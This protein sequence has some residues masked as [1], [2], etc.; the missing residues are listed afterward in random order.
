MNSPLASHETCNNRVKKEL[1][2]QG[3]QVIQEMSEGKKGKEI[4]KSSLLSEADCKEKLS[5]G[6]MD[7]DFGISSDEDLFGEPM[8]FSSLSE[9]LDR[10]SVV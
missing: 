2:R 7:E 8:A 3:N 5:S 4:S 6:L 9:I 1:N 10:K